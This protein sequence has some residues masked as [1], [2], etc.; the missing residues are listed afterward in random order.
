MAGATRRQ[1]PFRPEAG[2]LPPFLAGRKTGIALA[3]EMLDA[4]EADAPPPRGLLFFGPRGDGKTAVLARIAEDARRRGLRAENLSVAALGSLGALTRRLQEKAGL[5][6]TRVTS[7]QVGGAGITADRGEPTEDPGALLARWIQSAADPLV[8]LLDDVQAIELESGR[9]FFDAVQEATTRTLL[10]VLLTAGTP[11]SPRRLR[12]VGT[13]TERALRRMPLGR[14]ARAETI[15]AL[16]EP[17]RDTD[18]PLGDDA[19]AF[20]AAES[21][22]YP[23]FVQLLGSAAWRAAD[24]AATRNITMESARSGAAAARSEIEAFYSERFDEAR[25]RGVHRALGPLAAL[26]SEQG[27]TID[28]E[29]L[30]R[31]LE[32][33]AP[34]DEEAKL[35]ETLKDLGVLWETEP[36][37]WEL[38]IPSF[39]DHI[40]RRQSR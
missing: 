39:G 32:R 20:L 15:R 5:A 33:E 25:G 40:L 4:L 8:I 26:I 11:D 12:T 19:A 16:A 21:Q 31:F 3:H 35:L 10:F 13:F 28:D 30:D 34:A 29:T 37:V 18:L 17:A 2:A 14:L 6:G 22:D 38:G 9:A 36:A 27:G 23:Y 1:N 24:E 7:V